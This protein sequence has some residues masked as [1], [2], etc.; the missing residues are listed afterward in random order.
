LLLIK[1]SLLELGFLGRSRS[2]S[3]FLKMNA[4]RFGCA[5][6]CPAATIDKSTTRMRFRT[7][8][9]VDLDWAAWLELAK[10]PGA[11]VYVRERLMRHRVHD[12]SET[13]GA[14]ANGHRVTEDAG[15]LQG[16]WPRPIAKA[17]AATYG[18]AYGSNESGNAP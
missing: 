18:I 14:I 5:I 8:L 17:I 11:F 7:D 1:R 2:A 16:L 4:L 13:S 6:C 10:Q 15:I 12:G 3:T 9:R